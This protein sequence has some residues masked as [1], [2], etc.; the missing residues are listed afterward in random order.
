[1]FMKHSYLLFG[2]KNISSDPFIFFSLC[3]FIW[4]MNMLRRT[5]MTAIT[6]KW[7]PDFWC[8]GLTRCI[9]WKSVKLKPFIIAHFQSDFLLMHLQDNRWYLNY[10]GS[11]HLCGWNS[12]VLVS[13]S[14]SLG[15]WGYLLIKQLMGDFSL[16]CLCHS[17]LQ[18]K[19]K[20]KWKTKEEMRW[21]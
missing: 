20:E 11:C 13:A 9:P 10:F 3:I 6:T 17:D 14:P 7:G 5:A 18:I 16:L 2:K 8:C 15:C 12:W 1:M 4:K 19:N 21:G